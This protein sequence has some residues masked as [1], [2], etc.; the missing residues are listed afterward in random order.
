[1]GVPGLEVEVL[2]EKGLTHV[3]GVVDGLKVE[4]EGRDL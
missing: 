1:V 2:E 4:M 3:E